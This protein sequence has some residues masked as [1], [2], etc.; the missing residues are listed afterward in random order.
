MISPLSQFKITWHGHACFSIY[1]KALN[2]SVIFDPFKRETG[3]LMLPEEKGD[4]ILCT[5]DHFDHNNCDAVAKWDSAKFIQL[6]GDR[7]VKDVKIRGVEAFHDEVKGKK[8]GPNAI[9][10][11]N[12]GEGVFV[13]LGDL[14]HIL[15]EEQVNKINVFGRPHIVFVPVGGVY[16]IDP[17]TAVFVIKQL[18]PRIAIPMHYYCEKLNPKIF[19]KLHRLEDFLSEWDGPIEKFETN[20]IEVNIHELPSDTTVYVLKYP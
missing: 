15:T 14:G 7:N 3:R 20:A 2:L 4:I 8:R 12:M 1:N 16:T 17:E 11:V 5:H 6:I 13:H 18:N 9:Y 19:S 10:V